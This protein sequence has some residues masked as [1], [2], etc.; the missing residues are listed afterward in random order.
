RDCLDLMNGGF[1]E[2]GVYFISVHGIANAVPVYCDM[3]TAGG[4]WLVVQ[5][6]RDGS[7]NFNRTWAEYA[8]G[9]GDPSGENW[10]GNRF[11]H[12]LSSSKP[13]ELRVELYYKDS[14]WKFASYKTFSVASERDNF[15][16]EVGTFSGDISDALAFHDG[17]PF[18]AHNKDL[19]A[20]LINCAQS[21]GGGWW[22]AN[23]GRCHLNTVY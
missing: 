13:H 2:S 23:C 11:I 18:S 4:G 14:G 12:L 19:D 6:R 3:D 21:F 1:A 20:A 17:S 9:F 10:Q 7:V 22:F 5:K 16:L 15:R 8:N